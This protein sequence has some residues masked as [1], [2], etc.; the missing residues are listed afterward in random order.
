MTG[1][2]PDHANRP[3]HPWRRY[4]WVAGALL[5]SLLL[6]HFGWEN[7]W[8]ALKTAQP[9]LLLWMTALIVAGFWIRAWKWRFALG[10]G[11]PGIALF[12]VAKLAGN[13]TPG[14]AGEFSPLLFRQHRNAQV[15]V[16]IL[17]DRLLEVYLTLAFGLAGLHALNLTAPALVWAG[18][19]VWLL[20][21]AV[22]LWVLY[23]VDWTWGA[24]AESP[25]L[26][27]RI[28][29]AM[30]ALQRELR[31]LRGRFLAVLG[32]TLLAK[33]TDIWAVMLLCAAFG[34][35]A[36]FL[37][38]CAARCAHALVS[39]IP[40]TPDATGIPFVAAAYVLHVYAGIPYAVLTVA[41]GME[42]AIINGVLWC[43]FLA[44]ARGLFSGQAGTPAGGTGN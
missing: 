20:G 22:F 9:G 4:L 27:R 23:R 44:G 33:A 18:G 36:A 26:T 32:L 5:F 34:Y 29:I 40:V 30:E 39:A 41:L 17:S 21:A 19:L 43:S 35:D 14:R 1:A 37:L 24:A 28:A 3:P 15:A 25:G 8:Q 16:W 13:W 12:F 7:L 31:L 2:P 38:V 11:E 10:P 42:V 6:A